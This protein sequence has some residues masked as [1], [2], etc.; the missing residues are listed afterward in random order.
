[1]RTSQS[2]SHTHTET[3]TETHNRSAKKIDK[4]KSYSLFSENCNVSQE[5]RCVSNNAVYFEC[6]HISQKQFYIISEK[7]LKM[8]LKICLGYYALQTPKVLD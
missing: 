4:F 1:M 2:L 8:H 7:N 5:E 6:C 3:H